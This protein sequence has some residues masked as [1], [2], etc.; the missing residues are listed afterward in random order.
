MQELKTISRH[1][2]KALINCTKDDL[3]L[4]EE[5]FY[6]LKDLQEAL[7]DLKLAKI[8]FETHIPLS[9][10][11][12]VLIALVEKMV[13]EKAFSVL[14]P[15][16]ELM[17]KHNRLKAIDLIIKKLLPH[18]DRPKTL[19]AVLFVQEKLSQDKL[20]TMQQKLEERFQSSIQINQE[21]LGEN[22]VRLSLPSLG[23]EMGFSKRSVLEFLEKQVIQSI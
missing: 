20:T 21:L 23:V 11:Q 12:S 10:K 13:S 6:A 1:Y 2:A 8:I 7:Q 15:L 16:L 19:E 14:K 17:L 5:I 22:G 9:M 3:G 18:L 4:L